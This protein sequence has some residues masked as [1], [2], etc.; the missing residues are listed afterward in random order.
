M[1]R[2]GFNLNSNERGMLLNNDAYSN[3]KFAYSDFLSGMK[4]ND[5]SNSP[6]RYLIELN[7][8]QE[9]IKLAKEKGLQVDVDKLKNR[10]L[11]IFGKLKEWGIELNT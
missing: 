11:E 9:L 3:L 7:F 1:N 4:D 8:V 10:E 5:L 6:N 2:I